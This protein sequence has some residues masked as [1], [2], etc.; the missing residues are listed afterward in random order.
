M[1]CLRTL[2]VFVTVVAVAG[3]ALLPEALAYVNAGKDPVTAYA[4]LPSPRVKTFEVVASRFAF[5]PATIDFTVTE[6]GTFPIVCAE[7]CGDGHAEMRGSLV[8]TAAPK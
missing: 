5:K 8:V 1:R 6:A 2:L 7:A 4:P 3:M